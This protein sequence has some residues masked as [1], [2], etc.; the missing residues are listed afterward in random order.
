MVLGLVNFA[1][2][3]LSQRINCTTI[4]MNVIMISYLDL[5]EKDNVLGIK[6]Y[7]KILIVD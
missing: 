1:K 6:D 7:L 3:Y 4:I 2:G 5:M